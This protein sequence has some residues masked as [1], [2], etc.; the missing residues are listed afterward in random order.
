VPFEVKR[1]FCN[2]FGMDVS[3]VKIIFQYPWSVEFF[4]RIVWSVQVDPKLVFKWMYEIIYGNIEKK[5]LDFETVIEKS[6]GHKRLSDL[7]ELIDDEKVNRN[8]AKEIA[9]KIVD[10]DTRMPS[11]IA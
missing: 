6:F 8:N 4:T 1:R 10:G 11:E 9:F 2:T 3:D 5:G 7:I